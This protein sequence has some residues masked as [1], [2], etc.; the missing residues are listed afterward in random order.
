ML[1]ATRVRDY[2]EGQRPGPRRSRDHRSAGHASRSPPIDEQ[3][4]AGYDFF[5]ADTADWG[6]TE[7]E[8]AAVPAGTEAIHTGSLATALEPGRARII[9]LVAAQAGRGNGLLSFDPN[10]RPALAGPRARAVDRVEQFVAASHVV[11]ASDEDLGWLYP[12]LDPAD[13]LRRWAT[14][15]PALAVLTRG[16]DGCSGR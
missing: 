13:A 14:L 10:V 15:G 4:R 11:K 3:G 16:A 8:L 9:E 7:A 2:A 1:S 6:W 12:D 5:V